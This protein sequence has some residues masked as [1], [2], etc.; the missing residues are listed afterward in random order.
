M[1]AFLTA[2]FG[3]LGLALAM[4]V[5]ASGASFDAAAQSA[6][7]QWTT[8]TT[9]T[10]SAAFS[11]STC[12]NAPPD[13]GAN[14]PFDDPTLFSSLSAFKLRVGKPASNVYMQY[15][16]NS[17]A[18]SN[19]DGD[20]Q[21]VL[22]YLLN[23]R[24]GA[25]A[26]AA[27]SSTNFGS[28]TVNVDG[29]VAQIFTITNERGTTATF[30]SAPG[31]AIG[32][33]RVAGGTC[34]SATTLLSGG[35]CT[36]SMLFKPAGTG[37]RSGAL[38]FTLNSA[39]GITAAQK[40]LPLNGTGVAA[41]A[42]AIAPTTS[43]AAPANFTSHVGVQTATQT[44]TLSNSGGGTVT[45]TGITSPSSDYI[46]GG[47]CAPAFVLPTTASTCTVTLAYRP[48]AEG[49]ADAQVSI[50]NSTGTAGT[51]FLH[52]T[53]IGDPLLQ[54]AAESP[55]FPVT[56][57]GHPVTRTVRVTNVG[58]GVTTVGTAGFPAGAFAAG[59]G[60]N[61]ATLA[62]GSGFCDLDVTFSPSVAGP[63]QQA[64]LSV[65]YTP[66]GATASRTFSASAVE[67]LA[68][69]GTSTPMQAARG[70]SSTRTVQISNPSGIST[71]LGPI[72][73]SGSPNFTITSTTCGAT[74]AVTACSVVI[75]FTPDTDNPVSTALN[76][77]YGPS[78][79]STTQS[80]SLT[81]SGST[82]LI[83]VITVVPPSLTFPATLPGTTSTPLSVDIGN[84]GNL[85]LAL[86][87]IALAD[88]VPPDFAIT[89]NTCGTSIAV[90]GPTCRVTVTFTPSTQAAR[91][92][93]IVVTHNAALGS[94]NIALSGT[95]LLRPIAS[96]SPTTLDFGSVV[97]NTDSTLQS[98]TL[99]NTGNLDLHIGTISITG[100]SAAEY[101]QVGSTC[102][103][104]GVVAPTSSCQI[105]VRFR[106]SALNNR[107]ASVQ[108]THDAAGS[109]SG[110][111]LTG[112]GVAAPA[113]DI[114]VNQ[115]ELNFAPIVVQTTS[116]AQSITVQNSGTANLVLSRIAPSG[117]AASDYA[118]SGTC[119]VA[120]PLLP[121]ATCSIVVTFT[122]SAV[123]PRNAPLSIESNAS[124]GTLSV[125]LNGTGLAVPVPAVSLSPSP[126]AFGPQTVGTPY[127]PGAIRLQNTGTAVLHITGIV[128]SGPG[129]TS[130][131]DCAATLLAGAECTIS[132]AFAPA[133]VGATYS[134]QV[135]VSS[136]APGSPHVVLLS[137]EGTATVVP[138]L[139]W[140]TVIPAL[141]FGDVATGT[142]SAIQSVQLLNTGPGGVTLNVVNAV[143]S[144]ASDFSVTGTCIP[145]LV[146]FRNDTC[147][148]DVS[149][150]PG[151]A[152][153]KSATIQVAST[154]T[155]PPDVQL[156]GNGL[157]G[158]SPG[159]SVSTTAL[160]FD[161]VRVGAQSVPSEITL[162][163]NG[164]GVVR[165][166]SVAVS[167]P[168]AIQT[169]TCPAAPFTLQAGSNCTV[170][171]TF[172]PQAEG[173]ATGLLSITTDASPATREASLSGNGEPP[174]NLSSGC[175][176]VSGDSLT[177][178]TLWALAFLAA[179]ALLYRRRAREAQRRAERDRRGQP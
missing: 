42:L 122:P 72:T 61:G 94:T 141:T 103:S 71:F 144:N 124:R 98:T 112:I 123:G 90:G 12:H 119:A 13:I 157:G 93:R 46:V 56:L 54:V 11:C 4:G 176:M 171:V 173:I 38:L 170:T 165:V 60:C 19:P 9:Y 145:G 88:N 168:Y 80:I 134:G 77:R 32:E 156:G 131:T 52:G 102:A 155:R 36:V 74:L 23:V 150:V 73:L 6:P 154:G 41:P 149:F 22:D 128:T 39:S 87:S 33:F 132:V 137:G 86:T 43:L 139:T 29:A 147:R 14:I 99:T 178:P 160:N 15:F 142:R 24:D 89:G 114:L 85:A 104:S 101:T 100:T 5:G 44:W 26:A 50:A 175:S 10:N 161:T 17:L 76:V 67:L 169:K 92:A 108:I 63:N 105:T 97:V 68:D 84:S 113:P 69:P 30:Q 153:A 118:L 91:N 117:A 21:A 143:G 127:P 37:P 107:D 172:Q 70:A 95:T 27:G 65:P 58:T 179:A 47:T 82:Q 174:A 40:S 45:L 167:G 116:P 8:T 20:R 3:R 120:T 126:L 164:S 31:P 138:V 75:T 35:S 96:L 83:P 159:L 162:S 121:N 177:D 57:V 49:Q 148:I 18:T 2:A 130:T 53:A 109:P 115:S 28:S 25:V 55:A 34:S 163:S 111:V 7:P 135:T 16:A 146:L 106:P 48:N 64:M 152:G 66:P 51:I 133:S 136:D 79:T 78:S 166:L 62:A 158:P 59:N 140:S 125:P 151:S 129:F 81:I 110:V 1:R